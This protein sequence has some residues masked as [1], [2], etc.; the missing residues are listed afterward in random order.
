MSHNEHRKYLEFNRTLS[1][2]LGNDRMEITR[3]ILYPGEFTRH[4]AAS[5]FESDIKQEYALI[6]D[7][8]H[9]QGN[10]HSRI[11]P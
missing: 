11:C 7:C 5:I 3:Y 2:P 9:I 4:K 1:S 10:S 6:Y 8:Q